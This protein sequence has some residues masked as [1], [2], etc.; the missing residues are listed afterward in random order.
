M[1]ALH[2]WRKGGSELWRAWGSFRLSKTSTQG[3]IDNLRAIRKAGLEPPHIPCNNSPVATPRSRR[4]ESPS[5]Q[6]RLY[7]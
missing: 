5:E 6:F 4:S 3:P 7:P 2:V 1:D